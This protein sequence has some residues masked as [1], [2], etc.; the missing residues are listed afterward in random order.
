MGPGP[1]LIGEDALLEAARSGDGGAFER[2]IGE[3][4]SRLHVHC[5]RMLGSPHDADDAL[6]EA[7]VRALA[8]GRLVRGPRS[9]RWVAEHE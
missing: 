3:H 4:R 1:A 9:G 8:D 6:Q 5:Y 2:L 7:L